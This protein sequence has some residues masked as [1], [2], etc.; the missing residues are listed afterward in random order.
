MI[1]KHLPSLFLFSFLLSIGVAL[2]WNNS[3]S[4]SAQ[5][6]KNAKTK[7]NDSAKNQ[8]IMPAFQERV[9]DPNMPKGL[10]AQQYQ[11]YLQEKAMYET[12]EAEYNR[13]KAAYEKQMRESGAPTS[14][15]AAIKTRIQQLEEEFLAKR[16]Q[17]S[18]TNLNK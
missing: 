11:Q 16:K 14:V 7:N 3:T 8:F 18:I 13:Q 15:K 17:D 10:T 6:N 9:A 1:K 2:A 5:Q 12:Q 4:K